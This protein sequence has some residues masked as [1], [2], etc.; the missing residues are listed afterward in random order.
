[1]RNR[2]ATLACAVLLA[3]ALAGCTREDPD[4]VAAGKAQEPEGGS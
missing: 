2:I 4:C 1:M 3:A